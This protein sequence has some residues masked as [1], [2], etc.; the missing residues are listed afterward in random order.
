M[1]ARCAFCN[2]S[3]QTGGGQA[4]RAA[5]K[6]GGGIAPGPAAARLAARA[7][8][9]PACKKALPRC[10][11]CLGHLGCP[12]PADLPEAGS[13]APL[14]AAAEDADGTAPSSGLGRWMVWC[15]SC[16]HGGHALHVEQWFARHTV[17]PVAGCDCQCALLDAGLDSLAVWAALE[18]TVCVT[19]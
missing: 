3:L 15:Q 6:R 5:P 19:W 17:C 14:P 18:L 7:S 12:N 16:R 13:A 10:A 2:A 1:F 4:A 9:C 8:A 11:L